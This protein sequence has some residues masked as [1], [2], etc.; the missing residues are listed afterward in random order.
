MVFEEERGKEARHHRGRNLLLVTQTK[1]HIVPAL[2]P[3]FDGQPRPARD[4]FGKGL[5]G[6][7]CPIQIRISETEKQSHDLMIGAF[8]RRK[9]G[10]IG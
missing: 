2:I 5:S 3:F 7:H 6:T 9:K 4:C 10:E 8:W 1:P